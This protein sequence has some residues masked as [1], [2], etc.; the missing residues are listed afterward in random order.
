MWPIQTMEYYSVLN[1]ND[2]PNHEKH[3]GTLN[4]L[5][6][7][8]RRQSEKATYCIIPT[9]L[10]FGKGKTTETVKKISG[11]QGIWGRKG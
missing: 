8:E 6:L 3:G 11:H 9:I 1:R 5:L 2:L 10:R 7:S 4:S